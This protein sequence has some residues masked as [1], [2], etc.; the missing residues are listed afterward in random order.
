MLNLKPNEIIINHVICNSLPYFKGN[1][2]PPINCNL[3]QMLNPAKFN[4]QLIKVKMSVLI[5]ITSLLHQGSKKS[6][7]L[8]VY[9]I[10]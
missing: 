6:F 5:A 4:S 3:L 2:H 1:M 10:I 9:L 8:N 7:S